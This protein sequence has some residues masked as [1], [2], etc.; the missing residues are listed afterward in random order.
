MKK[1][2]WVYVSVFVLLSVVVYAAVG[3]LFFKDKK[4]V[5]AGDTN[6][7][8]PTTYT[9]TFNSC[10][11]SD[12]D[13]QSVKEGENITKPTNPTRSGYEF[14]AWYCDADYTNKF[15]LN[16]PINADTTLYARWAKDIV[17]FCECNADGS[18]IDSLSK[19]N[20]ADEKIII[21]PKKKNGKPIS[22]IDAKAFMDCSAEIIIIPK[23]YKTIRD[24]AFKNC[25][26]KII[27]PNSIEIMGN[28]VFEGCSSSTEIYCET[29][30]P[31]PNIAPDG[32]NDDWHGGNADKVIWGYQG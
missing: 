22:E 30:N 17:D 2:I 31:A 28:C 6:V 11:G 4:P 8:V 27:V 13:S 25:N 15:N 23:N 16:T 20:F 1:N 21:L 32:W 29:E 7:D 18:R 19:K 5:D 14:Y 9:V 10:S 24:S 3:F 12:V 26:A